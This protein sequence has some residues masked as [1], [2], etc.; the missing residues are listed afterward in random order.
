MG[1]AI[2]R[3][4]NMRLKAV[5]CLF[6]ACFLF[7]LLLAVF[8]L[9]GN[10]SLT[11][12]AIGDVYLK[13]EC[14]DCGSVW[15]SHCHR[16]ECASFGENCYFKEDPRFTDWGYCYEKVDVEFQ[17][18]DDV[19][20]KPVVEAV[21]KVEG[22]D[23]YSEQCVTDGNGS[24]LLSDL[25]GSYS[26][27]VEKDGYVCETPHCIQSFTTY[28][29]ADPNELTLKP[30]RIS[31]CQDSDQGI[32]YCEKG[33][34]TD[35][36]GPFQDQCSGDGATLIE[37]YCQNGIAKT[38]SHKCSGSC[39]GGVCLTPENQ[40]VEVIIKTSEG[41]NRNTMARGVPVQISKKGSTSVLSKCL[42]NQQGQCRVN[43]APD[44]YVARVQNVFYECTEDFGCPRDFTV[45]DQS[46][47]VD[48]GLRVIPLKT[49]VCYDT[50]GGRDY[51]K[52]GVAKNNNYPS[53]AFDVIEDACSRGNILYEAYCNNY[54]DIAEEREHKCDYGCQDGACL[55]GVTF[56]V[57]DFLTGEPV[58]LTNVKV[59]LWAEA[60]SFQPTTGCTTDLEGECMVSLIPGKRYKA[61]VEEQSG[62][63]CV[64]DGCFRITCQNADCS[65][66]FTPEDEE[67]TVV[68]KPRKIIQ[69]EEEEEIIED[70][71]VVNYIGIEGGFYGITTDQDK[72]Y[73]PVNLTQEFK[74]DG[75]K[76]KF[77][78]KSV[79]GMASTIMWGEMI[80][81]IEIEK[82]E[83]VLPPEC[84]SEGREFSS[85]F[86]QWYPNKCCQGLTEFLLGMDTRISIADG[87]YETN[88]VT[89]W[90]VGVCLNCRNKT[91]EEIESVCSCPED[92]VGR[93]RSDFQTIKEFCQ[94]EKGWKRHCGAPGV[95][96]YLEICRMCKDVGIEAGIGPDEEPETP[97]AS[98]DI[99]PE[100]IDESAIVTIKPVKFALTILATNQGAKKMVGNYAY[101]Y[102]VKSEATGQD[103]TEFKQK[104][105]ITISYTDKEVAN[106]NEDFLTILYYD[107]SSGRWKPL[108]T[109]INKTANTATAEV[110]HFTGFALA[111]ETA[112]QEV[113]AYFKVFKYGTEQGVPDALVEVFENDIKRSDCRTNIQGLCSVV[114]IKDRDYTASASAD[115]YATV[116]GI[117]T[118]V[119]I[120]EK[121]YNAVDRFIALH[122]KEEAE[123]PEEP[124]KPVKV[125]VIFL[126]RDIDTEQEIDGAR[127]DLFEKA[128]EVKDGWQYQGSCTTAE[129]QGC[130]MELALKQEYRIDVRA[131]GYLEALFQNVYFSDAY[132]QP[133]RAVFLQREG[134]P[135]TEVKIEC[136]NVGQG[137]WCSDYNLWQTE[138]RGQGDIVKLEDGEYCLDEIG[139][140][141]NYCGTCLTSGLSTFVI[142]LHNG[143]N[144][145]SS[146]TEAPLTAAELQQN[147]SKILPF[148]IAYSP[149][150][151]RFFS[152]EQVSSDE[153][154]YTISV[155]ACTIEKRGKRAE[156]GQKAMEKGWNTISYYMPFD[157]IRGN[158]SVNESARL[159]AFN[160][161]KQLWYTVSPSYALNPSQGYWIKI[162]NDCALYPK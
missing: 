124:E 24:C 142:E 150:R 28:P 14:S 57:V 51:F 130:Q 58:P 43:L 52:K 160:S 137:Y 38:D 71:G 59:G 129:Q 48:V 152:A 117:E 54:Y 65:D 114:L 101:D 136:S 91:C 99:P 36:W 4:K 111:S 47:V 86:K 84:A 162:E 20:E 148:F 89:G 74:Q 6:M 66:S 127:I 9:L 100:A 30:K 147:C 73:R 154:A 140:K 64:A 134:S 34:A 42:T 37:Y 125:D 10:N 78:A 141:H 27:S 138:C 2:I 120:A 63:T 105:K 93:A 158:C 60:E 87:C 16:L 132:A 11:V 90:P 107:E 108:S 56:E 103:I 29:N 12:R 109:V 33:A 126:A 62:Y 161:A 72:K 110:D 76:V 85:I 151:G 115:G 70:T 41:K 156:I 77:K 26:A 53:L 19:K 97:K 49:Q 5:K 112:E 22:S 143:F 18:I 1:T 98:I 15:N 123:E 50:D 146:P 81:I 96:G 159:W 61:L 144:F 45:C 118:K 80:E 68:L 102:S 153:G 23:G 75:L 121:D 149:E 25:G 17:V 82:Q 79:K 95:N 122:L 44:Q 7:A 94:S 13:S 106:L 157:V 139:E 116:E 155:G 40:E 67:Y 133:K 8:N 3:F 128:S 83:I 31:A 32:N 131:N 69:G 39:Q 35:V 92:C 46:Q 21:V 113:T 55:T 104:V 88:R 135:S 145:I 119:F